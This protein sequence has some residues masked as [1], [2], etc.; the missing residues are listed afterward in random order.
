MKLHSRGCSLTTAWVGE[1]VA[2]RVVATHRGRPVE[3]SILL[4]PEQLRSI[5]AE[6]LD[7]KP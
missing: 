1:K 3:I 6:T 2:L 7:V 5:V 4:T